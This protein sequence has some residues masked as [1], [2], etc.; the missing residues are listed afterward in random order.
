MK[1]TNGALFGDDYML[2][3]MLDIETRDSLL[4]VKA[5]TTPFDY[6]MRITEKNETKLRKVDVCETF[7]YLKGLTVIRQD[8]IR[9]FDTS[10]ICRC[11]L[12]RCISTVISMT[13]KDCALT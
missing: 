1:G 3:Y 13:G 9:R 5:F 8:A 11:S 10:S 12:L 2:Q 4:N 7:N 6:E